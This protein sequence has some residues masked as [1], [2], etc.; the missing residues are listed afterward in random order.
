MTVQA[1]ACLFHASE[2]Q[3]SCLFRAIPCMFLALDRT[4]QITQNPCLG[5]AFALVLAYPTLQTLF[6]THLHSSAFLTKTK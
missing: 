6:I 1:T 5:L 2:R 4:K 3:L